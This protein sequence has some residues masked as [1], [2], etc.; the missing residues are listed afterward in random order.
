MHRHV[1]DSSIDVD[2]FNPANEI[3]DALRDLH[4]T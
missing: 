3:R 4:A 2:L 1:D